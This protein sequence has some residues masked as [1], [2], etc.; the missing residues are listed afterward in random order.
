MSIL[1]NAIGLCLLPISELRGGLPYAIFN[2]INPVMAY[3]ICVVANFLVIP[4]VYFFLTFFHGH[5][6]KWNFYN[7]LFNR[8]IENKRNNFK[9]YVGTKFEFIALML[10]V[11]IPLPIT[12]AYTGTIVAWLF[13]LKKKK[14]YLAL[15]LGVLIAGLIVTLVSVLGINGLELFIKHI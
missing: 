4:M 15:G 12:G 7:K 13:G 6:M 10:F 9:K 14:A 2:G 5:F 11:A 1:I 8:Y 3:F